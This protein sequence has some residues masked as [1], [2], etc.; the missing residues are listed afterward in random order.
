MNEI[1]LVEMW[2]N[3]VKRK[4]FKQI[5]MHPRLISKGDVWMSGGGKRAE[6][7]HKRTFPV[8]SYRC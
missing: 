8:G 3:P 1:S 5:K 4:T 7:G 6:D 2:M